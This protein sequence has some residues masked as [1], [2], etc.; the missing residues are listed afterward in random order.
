MVDRRLTW[1]AALVLTWAAAIFIQLVSL[2]IIHHREYLGKAAARQEVSIEIPAPRG[3]IF[4]RSGRRLAMSVSTQSVYVNPL[5]LPD[6]G[7]AAELLAIVLDLD[8][9]QLE[10][11]L[12]EAYNDGRGFLWIKRRIS[13][14][15]AESLRKL[16][17]DWIFIA[18]ESQRHYPNNK[19]A[20]HLLGS[21]NSEEKGNAGIEMAL[22]AELRGVPGKERVLTDAKRHN[23]SSR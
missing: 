18:Q 13:Q 9:A 20:A 7:V 21:V 1:L 3:T 10:D 12:R 4:S 14:N 17:I 23:I 5:K 2:Q 11:K 16:S 22:D 19:L 6:L 15:E 8:R